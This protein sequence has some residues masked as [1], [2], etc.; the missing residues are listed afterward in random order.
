MDQTAKIQQYIQKI[1]TDKHIPEKRRNAIIAQIEQTATCDFQ[2]QSHFK[3]NY[4]ARDIEEYKDLLRDLQEEAIILLYARSEVFVKYL[5]EQIDTIA[6]ADI[7]NYSIRCN[8]EVLQ[9]IPSTTKQKFLIVYETGGD[10]EKHMPGILKLRKYVI[11]YFTEQLQIK[12]TETDVILHRDQQNNC[13]LI[14][15]AI[16]KTKE[17]KIKIRDDLK[18][19]IENCEQSNDLT[20]KIDDDKQFHKGHEDYHLYTVNFE[21]AVT[22]RDILGNFI[23][24]KDLLINVINKYPMINATT[25]N[26]TINITTNNVTNNITNNGTI[27]GDIGSNIGNIHNS[28]SGVSLFLHH[29][30]TNKPEWYKEGNWMERVDLKSKYEAICGEKI[31]DIAFKKMASKNFV[32]NVRRGRMNGKD[33]RMYRLKYIKDLKN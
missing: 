19:Y 7:Q 8:M 1:L 6:L 16:V 18:N 5:K 32:S 23:Q 28:L 21:N 10:I 24:N 2:L 29:V 4:D 26:V 22:T 20:K 33:V 31:S 12:L 17:E 9:M 30:R 13:L 25:N 14:V 15:N 27:N 11:A 3:Q